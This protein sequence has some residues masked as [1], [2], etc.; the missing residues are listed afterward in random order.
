MLAH[1]AGATASARLTAGGAGSP[2]AALSARVRQSARQL[3]AP[4]RQ[5]SARTRLRSASPWKKWTGPVTAG[6]RVRRAT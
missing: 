2:G 5:R 1:G 4:V 6:A 3:H